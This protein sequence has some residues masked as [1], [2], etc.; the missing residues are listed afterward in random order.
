MTLSK[1]GT[2]DSVEGRL[3]HPGKRQ[4]LADFCGA[5]GV[6]PGLTSL[7]RALR[8]DLRIL[9]YHRVR[10]LDDADVFDFDINLI[11]ASPQQFREQMQLVRQHYDPMSF[12]DLIVAIDTGRPLPAQPLIV[13]FDD[14]YEDNYSVA[15]PILHELGVP[16]T[17]F[18]STGHIDNGTPY[19]YDWLVHAIC[20][21]TA[22]WLQVPEL[23]ID[24]ALPD[25]LAGRREVADELL[26]ELKGLDAATQTAVISR[27][28]DA[29]GMPAPRTHAECRPMTWDQLRE[30]QLAGM[31]IG[32]HGVSHRILAKLLPVE[33]VAEIRESK[34]S[35]ERELG[36]T[37]DVISY[38]VGGPDAYDERVIAAA[39]EAGYRMACNYLTGVNRLPSMPHHALRRLHVE[40]EMD[41]AWFAAMTAL[42]EVFAYQKRQ[43]IS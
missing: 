8:R 17:F 28:E 20:L 19:V 21:T 43:R 42:P 10:E 27:M 3:R 12:H 40:R 2:T 32:S 1:V 29:W 37:A 6:L 4:R 15:F 26:F 23:G 39:K 7:R 38:P 36:V 13:T 9:A 41:L 31:E 24:Q 5:I 34:Q 16:A 22:D 33:M 11:S 14:G 35:L 25:T 18:V 30:M